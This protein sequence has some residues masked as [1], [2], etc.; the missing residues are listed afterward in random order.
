MKTLAPQ[1]T[2]P[3][4]AVKKVRKK[5]RARSSK[6]PKGFG[7]EASGAAVEAPSSM[8]ALVQEI[9]L[10]LK[11]PKTVDSRRELVLKLLAERMR[12][13][14]IA[15]VICPR[16]NVKV[17]TVYDD[18]AWGKKYWLNWANKMGRDEALAEALSTSQEII[19]RCMAK[20]DHQGALLANK[21]YSELLKL[22]R[23]EEQAAGVFGA[24]LI[25]A[26]ATPAQWLEAA[27]QMAQE[28]AP[29]TKK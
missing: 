16:F 22:T 11:G 26:K 24:V 28:P 21:H 7:P 5:A 14:A 9:Y 25:P 15:N 2:P 20:G 27:K 12:P 18:I 13:H 1:A 8:E 29:E 6:A 4:G 3:Q 17:R 10:A 19:R 23:S